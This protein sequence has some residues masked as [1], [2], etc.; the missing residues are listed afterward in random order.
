[1]AEIYERVVTA[2]SRTR[3]NYKILHR[4]AIYDSEGQEINANLGNQAQ[5]LID[6]D[7][8][9]MNCLLKPRE[10]ATSYKIEI[11]DPTSMLIET[12]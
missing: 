1:M 11:L 3:L 8:V 2:L 7:I 10:R 4:V 6:G 9:E 5:P 12:I